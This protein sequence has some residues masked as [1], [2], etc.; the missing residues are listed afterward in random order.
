VIA[1]YIRDSW[2]LIRIAKNAKAPIDPKWPDNAL[3]YQEAVTRVK[4]G[5]NLAVVCGKQS[6]G[7]LCVDIDERKQGVFIKED[8]DY[9]RSFNTLVD[10]SRH[11]YH[12]WYRT[13][14]K[15]IRNAKEFLQKKG[16]TFREN[17]NTIRWDN[18]YVLICPSQIDS[19]IYNWLDNWK[20]GLR[21][22]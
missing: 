8:L 18:Q 6:K 22:I 20:Q 7:L 3:T 19:W 14:Q 5:N 15:R 21:V 4:Y 2:H 9:Y 11:G 17:V 13:E 10:F 16:L 1:R 12:V